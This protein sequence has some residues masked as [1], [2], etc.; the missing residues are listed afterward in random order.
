MLDKIHQSRQARQV[1]G[2]IP[3]HHRYTLG[4]AGERFFKALR[5]RQELLASPCPQC[6]DRLLP[7]KLYCERCFVETTEPWEAVEGAGFVRSFTVLHR[8]LEEEALPRP[9]VVAMIS[10]PGVRGGLIHRLQEVEPHRVTL[11]MAV[12]P[13]WAPQRVGAMSDILYFRPAQA[14]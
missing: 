1:T 10:W 9:E 5:D 3:I 11:G 14:D 8:S 7:P 2:E 12:S 6:R 4:V 13:V